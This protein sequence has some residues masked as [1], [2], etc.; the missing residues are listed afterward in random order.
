MNKST[1]ESE[2]SKATEMLSGKEVSQVHRHSENEVA[3]IF[4]DGTRLFIDKSNTG[5][6]LSITGGTSE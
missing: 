5:V 1:L 2:A 4:T 3:I 6:E